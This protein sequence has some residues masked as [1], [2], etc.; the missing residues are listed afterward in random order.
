MTKGMFSFET[1]DVSWN[2][3]WNMTDVDGNCTWVGSIVVLNLSSNAL[4]DSVFRC[5]PP[6]IKVLGSSIT[7]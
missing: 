5:Y 4:T 7:E 3:F 1:L 2:S 6:Q